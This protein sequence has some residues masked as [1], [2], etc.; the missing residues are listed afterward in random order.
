MA[1]GKPAGVLAEFKMTNG[2][3]PILIPVDI[4][5]RSHMFVLDTGSSTTVFD[6]SLGHRPGLFDPPEP[7]G[8]REVV[9]VES[10]GGTAYL[11]LSNPPESFVGREDL[12][13]LGRV[14]WHDLNIL[15]R[16]ADRD[17]RGVL[18][19]DFLKHYVVRLDF[20]AGSVALLRGDA[21]EHPEWGIALAMSGSRSGSDSPVVSVAGL[22]DG[23]AEFLIDTGCTKNGRMESRLFKEI[24]GAQATCDCY[25]ATSAGIV[26][27]KSARLK[28]FVF[29]GVNHKGLAFDEA[30]K[31]ILGLGVLSRYVV[32]FDFPNRKLYL[33]KGKYAGNPDDQDMSGLHLWRVN[34]SVT[35]HS[36]D[37][38]SPADGAGIQAGDVIITVGGKTSVGMDLQHFNRLLSSGDDKEI[39]MVIKRGGE[40]KAVS[41]K[42]KNRI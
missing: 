36:V 16:V 28:E 18:G 4:G 25:M 17:I 11:E 2:G 8:S 30:R 27:T 33:K 35:V 3:L 22:N 19:M 40:G 29:A 13:R 7:A 12:R 23:T 37:R 15:R 5:G 32:T 20:D 39:T 41:F 34:G 24:F 6:S 10:A 9:A 14:L 26:A 21:L 31:N 1:T 38:D 42:L